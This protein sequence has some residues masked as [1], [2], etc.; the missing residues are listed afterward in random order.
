[1]F[2][3]Q[4]TLFRLFGIDVRIDLSW[5][6]I[7]V[8]I[9]WSLATGY[10]PFVLPELSALTY[11]GMGV[12]GLIG[13]SVSIVAHEFSHS[14]VARHYDMR[15][16]HITLFVFGGVAEL[17]GE[18]TSAKAELAVAIAGPLMSVAVAAAFFILGGLLTVLAVGE[19]AVAVADYLGTINLILAGFN[20]VPA[21]PLD[22]GRVLRAW[23][24]RAKGDYIGATRT[25]ARVGEMFGFL[26]MTLALFNLFTGNL[27]GAIW[28]FLIGMFIRG[29]AVATFEQALDRDVLAK[30]PAAHFM[31]QPVI[32]VPAGL[33]VDALID[34]YLF[35][36]YFKSFPVADDGRLRGVVD[37]RDVQ[38]VPAA[39]RTG[40]TVADVMRA[41]D[42]NDTIAADAPGI[43]AL[44]QM[45]RAGRAR[46][47]VVEGGRLVGVVALRD[48]LN[49]LEFHMR[50][51]RR[52][53]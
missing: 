22:G 28:F 42:E 23:L 16:R 7:A 33:P 43:Q 49:F 12:A 3:R 50:L 6:A 48:M 1:M 21:F 32:V 52:G 5:L 11:W 24:W 35:R 37:I 8:L 44:Q 30:Q 51:D 15:I 13:L 29:A 2:S 47:F 20:L 9:S 34:E 18:P 4:I 17:E 14:L 40:L 10:F 19:P 31:R 25:A 36:Y 26:L 38:T 39:E 45:R 53:R 27:L 46:V 41:P